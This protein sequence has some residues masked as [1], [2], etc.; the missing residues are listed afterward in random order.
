[1]IKNLSFLNQ[2][3]FREQIEI[4]L[5]KLVR[6]KNSELLE[7]KYLLEDIGCQSVRD[8]QSNILTIDD[9]DL[10]EYKISLRR[11]TSD[12]SIFKYILLNREYETFVTQTKDV[13]YIIDAGANIG[14][15]TLYFKKK[16]PFST[17]VSIEPEAE[18]FRCLA[19]NIQLNKFTAIHPLNKGLW[20]DDSPLKIGRNFGD[21]R[22]WSFTVEP[23][24]ESPIYGITIPAIMQE[25][26]M[27][28]IDILKIDIEGAERFIFETNILKSFLHKVRYIVMEIH[29]NQFSGLDQK[30]Y[31]LLTDFGFDYTPC[32]PELTIAT[33][34]NN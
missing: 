6:R 14:C 28:R 8:G 20:V 2:Y 7:L 19:K 10:G 9:Q 17:I 30:I 32:G 18:N 29:K 25:Y 13:R 34:K 12:I 22:E 3:S 1:M 26:S 27:P 21:K 33:N 11:R 23:V 5:S 31:K 16:F 24:R 15:S 4:I